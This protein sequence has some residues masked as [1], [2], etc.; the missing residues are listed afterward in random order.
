[1]IVFCDEIEQNRNL[2]EQY[3][4]RV[5]NL[6]RW[7]KTTFERYSSML[8]TEIG[9][10]TLG[11][12][13][14]EIN[15]DP[16]AI[17][18]MAQN[19]LD[20]L[21]YANGSK[22]SYF[23]MSDALVKLMLS[24][25][26]FGPGPNNQFL[27]DC[28]IT[29]NLKF[30]STLRSWTNCSA[31]VF[32][33]AEIAAKVLRDK[34]G[35]YRIDFQAL[36]SDRE[37]RSKLTHSGE[38]SLCLSAMRCYNVVRE[39][40]VFM[41][42]DYRD[43]LPFFVFEDQFDY[44]RMKADPCHFSFERTTTILIADSVHDVRKD[45][46]WAV[47]NLP[48][49]LVIDLDGYSDCGGLLEM[50]EHNRIQREILCRRVSENLTQLPVDHTLWYR[51]GEYQSFDYI[52]EGNLFI[53]AYTEFHKD[54]PYRNRVT[55]RDKLNNLGEILKNLLLCAKA[56]DRIINIVALTSNTSFVKRL[57][58]VVNRYDVSLDDY[59]IT[60]VGLASEKE[61]NEV[62]AE[63][64]GDQEDMRDHFCHHN[65][66]TY[67]FYQAFAENS[68]QW[69]HRQSLES[70]FS[71]PSA[72]G[73]VI[74]C[75]NERNNLANEF[76]PLYD[77]CEEEN[78]ERSEEMRLQF[79]SGKAAAWNTIAN[80]YVPRLRKNSE[81]DQMKNTIRTVLGQMQQTPQKRLFF[82]NHT[83][84]IGGSTLA[85]QLVW[86][87][88]MDFAVLEVRSF[89]PKTFKRRIEHLYD[90]VL[91]KSPIILF[92]DDTLPFFKGLCD[93]VC[94]LDRRCVLV[95]ACRIESGVI[96]TYPDANVK[97]V[98]S[99]QDSMIPILRERYRQ[100]SPLPEAELR[101]KD[102]YFSEKIQGTMLTPFI[103]GLY[104]K[105]KDFNIDT[106]VRKA[107]DGCYERRYAD[108]LAYI[109]LCDRYEC[110]NLPISFVRHI[111]KISLRD[112]Y[113]RIVP[114]AGSLITAERQSSG[115]ECYHFMHPLLSKCFLKQYC[116]RYYGGEANLPNAI[117]EL[118]YRLI[119]FMVDASKA[120]P[121]NAPHLEILISIM[122]KNK[123]MNRDNQSQDLSAL[124][125]DIG[126]PESQRQLMR[127]LAERFQPLADGIWST[128]NRG[129]GEY[130]KRNEQQILRLVSHAYAHLGCMYSKDAHNHAEAF[131]CSQKAINYR[132]DDD[133]DVFHMAGRT[134]ID[135]LTQ[136]FDDANAEFTQETFSEIYQDVQKA[137]EYFDNSICFGSPH[138]GYPSKLALLYRVLKFLFERNQIKSEEDLHKLDPTARQL[139][140]K[141]MNT[142]EE[143]KNYSYS[144]EIAPRRIAEYESL[145]HSKI[146]FGN[147]SQAVEYYQNKVDVLRNGHDIVGYGNS[148]RSLIYAQIS[149]SRNKN[150]DLPFYFS[151]KNPRK[152]LT[153]IESLLLQPFDPERFSDYTLRT[154]MFHYWMKLAKYLDQPIDK[155]L[156]M[157]RRWMTMEEDRHNQLN[158]E[159]YYYQRVLLYLSIKSGNTASAEELHDLIHRISGYDAD[160]LFDRRRGKLGKIRDI[161]VSG[162]EM[163]QL[164]DVTICKDEEEYLEFAIDQSHTPVTVFAHF[165]DCLNQGLALLKIYDPVAWNKEQVRMNIGRSSQSSL[166]PAQVGHRVKFVL[167][168]STNY[169]VALSH[170]AADIDA[171]EKMNLPKAGSVTKTSQAS[172]TR[173]EKKE[174]PSSNEASTKAVASAAML[175]AGQRTVL[176]NISISSSSG[177]WINGHVDDG[178]A[179]VSVK[180]DLMRFPKEEISYYGGVDEVLKLLEKKAE[181]PCLIAFVVE[182]GPRIRYR[183]SLFEANG[184]IA[185][186]LGETSNP[187]KKE[188]E[189]IELSTKTKAE[190]PNG[191]VVSATIQTVQADTANCVFQYKGSMYSLV[192]KVSKKK[193]RDSLQRAVKQKIPVKTRIVGYDKEIYTGKLV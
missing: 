71:L 30:K 150:P 92:A 46:R 26:S 153:D 28:G 55:W 163:G 120:I 184:S 134:L 176:R 2:R 36:S 123:R 125:M 143:A 22:M 192:L 37:A 54:L 183:A 59:F 137:E 100:V 186:M 166:T 191:E 108:V 105:E 19:F 170:H 180:D 133:P 118:S 31:G 115:A 81:F 39:M 8:K 16:S 147:Y 49:N 56:C 95:S 40:L 76:F 27:T 162:K 96:R 20:D 148:L 129:S 62:Y 74:L 106:Y 121:E 68:S 155:G 79:Y 53:G 73:P 126:M 7:Y 102:T 157:A 172:D 64:N 167:G 82:I 158:P 34:V 159:P 57:L 101:L 109:A 45:Y 132:P 99:V 65:C 50:V 161:L 86:D 18:E 66:L 174:L 164:F 145:F 152:M 156:A 24:K 89:D 75:E 124:M 165:E 182:S 138:Y 103:I 63:Y 188:P 88:H 178:I 193:E 154:Q 141:F 14:A 9:M 177:R 189:N 104:Y 35:T 116:E 83:A 111:L 69:E 10:E 51:C 130:F 13:L 146:V 42:P 135:K 47:A 70:N 72:N 113:L 32:E 136:K 33:L 97:T 112:E 98:S 185:E 84:G 48:W 3:H 52:P 151:L 168:F 5:R 171:G 25:F 80:E 119:D 114:S 11:K 43:Q 21:D 93:E 60:W 149:Q 128:H 160:N 179:G 140:A 173:P 169:L 23:T 94:R 44:D 122:I 58:Q 181:I 107:L 90:I 29:A 187:K 1:M 175:K 117:F 77:H 6:A 144:D 61:A 85:R 131:E 38:A 4:R 41:D 139:Q 17:S 91:D 142:L 190:V 12:E 127:H 15:V 67:Q 78:P 87:L 110:K